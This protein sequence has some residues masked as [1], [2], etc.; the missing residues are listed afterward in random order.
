MAL[1]RSTSR[2]CGSAI[3]PQAQPSARTVCERSASRRRPEN[4]RT[5]RSQVAQTPDANGSVSRAE[6]AASHQAPHW[7]AAKKT[8]KLKR[9]GRTT[10]KGSEEEERDWQDCT[11]C[12]AKFQEESLNLPRYTPESI[13]VLSTWPASSGLHDKLRPK[14]L[15][16][17]EKYSSRI[18]AS[19][20]FI[21]FF[22]RGI[23]PIKDTDMAKL[24]AQQSNAWSFGLDIPESPSLHPRD[25]CCPLAR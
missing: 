12:L 6:L 5:R 25:R 8:E 9:V 13:S 22:F 24:D 4:A 11:F 23:C 10:T 15:K 2:R 14:N 3:F 7:L 21:F 20:F 1:Q 19:L 16:I 17:T 18:R